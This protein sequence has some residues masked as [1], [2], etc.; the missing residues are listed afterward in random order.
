MQNCYVESFNGRMRS[1]LPDETP[2]LTIADARVEIATWLEDY[3]RKKSAL[4]TWPRRRLPPKWTGNGL[5]Q[6]ALRPAIAPT[7]LM[8]NKVARL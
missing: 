3:N 7:A 4:A 5:L 8:H 6:Y 2:S 1:E